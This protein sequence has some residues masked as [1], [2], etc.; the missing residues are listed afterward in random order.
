LRP[1]LWLYHYKVARLQASSKDWTGALAE[2]EA[3]LRLNPF[4]GDARQLQV[5]C[6]LASGKKD[7]A[8]SAFQAL[9]AVVPGRAEEMRRLFAEQ[10]R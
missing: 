1:R 4:S 8:R 7:Q 2:C 5:R 6:L 10:L 3:A 9:L